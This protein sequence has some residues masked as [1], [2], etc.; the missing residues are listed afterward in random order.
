MEIRED[1]CPRTAKNFV[2]LAKAPA[3]QG[4]KSS[5][6]HRVIPQFMCQGG[7]FTNDNGTGGRSI[8]G[9]KFPDE[10]FELKHTGPGVL[11]MANAGPNT[12][13][14]QFVSL[15][16][17]GGARSQEGRTRH[18]FA[19]PP[20]PPLRGAA[21]LPRSQQNTHTPHTHPPAPPAP[22]KNPAPAKKQFLCTATT[23][24]LDGKHVVFGQVTDGFSVVKAMEACGSRSGETAYDVMIADS[25]VVARARRA[26]AAA[27]TTAA[28]GL[29]LVQQR[30]GLAVAAPRRAAVPRA[31]SVAGARFA[32]F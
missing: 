29:R 9:A 28:P 22:K 16:G 32:G 20:P 13:G 24:W 27:K 19:H 1:V 6:F 11:S 14:S 23:P 8:Y 31:G 25:G 17:G 7:D 10:S 30:R 15:S 3:G 5:R 12:N 2:E 26:A 4:F 18:L 21:S